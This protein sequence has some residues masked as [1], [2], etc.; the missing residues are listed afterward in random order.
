LRAGAARIGE[1]AAFVGYGSE[2]ALTRAFKA[3]FGTTPAR[4]RR[5]G[6]TQAESSAGLDRKAGE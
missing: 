5:E 3:Q 2:A 4:F 6:P 1:I